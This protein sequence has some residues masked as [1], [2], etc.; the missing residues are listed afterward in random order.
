MLRL[1]CGVLTACV[2]VVALFNVAN[3]NWEFVLR[4]PSSLDMVFIQGGEFLMGSDNPEAYPQD[5]EGPVRKVQLWLRG[6][7]VLRT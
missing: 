5:G 2:L 4:N 6:V 7:V 1:I 3:D